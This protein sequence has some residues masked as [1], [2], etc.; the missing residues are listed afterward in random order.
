MVKDDNKFQVSPKLTLKAIFPCATEIKLGK[1][2]LAEV[3]IP[4]ENFFLTTSN[5]D[6]LQRV[7]YTMK[8]LEYNDETKAVE[9]FI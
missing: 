3:V 8:R 1:N 9:I 6:L 4:I 5:F 7:G 2:S